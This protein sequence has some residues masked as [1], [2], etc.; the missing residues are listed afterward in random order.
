VDF[1]FLS[2]LALINLTACFSWVSLISG[3]VFS[4]IVPRSFDPLPL[5]ATF[6]VDSFATHPKK[7]SIS[8]PLRAPFF[9]YHFRSNLAVKLASSLVGALLSPTAL[10]PHSFDWPP[11][12]SCGSLTHFVSAST[13]SSLTLLIFSLPVSPLPSG[14]VVRGFRFLFAPLAAPSPTS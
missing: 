9:L 4:L 12:V 3:S 11:Q 7:A 6:F 8:P 14:D 1:F 5:P 13:G 10:F 2:L